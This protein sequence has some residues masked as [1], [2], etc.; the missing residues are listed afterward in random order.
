MATNI[1]V[2]CSDDQSYFDGSKLLD[3]MSFFKSKFTD[4]GVRFSKFRTAVP[5][6]APGRVCLLTGLHQDEHGLIYNDFQPWDHA[7]SI[8]TAL[9]TAGYR[10][11]QVGKW[12][13]R[14]GLAK[15][16]RMAKRVPPGWNSWYAFEDSMFV[17]G[18]FRAAGLGAEPTDGSTNQV[19]TPAT[20]PS[21]APKTD[22]TVDSGYT[23]GYS[24]RLLAKRAWDVIDA[25]N[26]LNVPL[27]LWVAPTAPHP[28]YTIEGW[29]QSGNDAT[30]GF[31]SAAGSWN[32]ANFNTVG[33]D[34]PNW[35]STL[36]SYNGGTPEGLE[37]DERV[38]QSMDDLF[39]QVYN[40]MDAEGRQSGA[41]STLYIYVADNGRAWGEH[42][43]DKKNVAHLAA[44]HIPFAAYWANGSMGAPR[45]V[46]SLWS[47]IDLAP[48]LAEVAVPGQDVT[49]TLGYTP[50]GQSF[51]GQITN[52]GG[53]TPT[54]RFFSIATSEP[55]NSIPLWTG[56]ETSTGDRY[57]KYP[58]EANTPR[59]NEEFYEIGS[60]SFEQTNRADDGGAYATRKAELVTLLESLQ[61]N[62]E[63][64]IF[65]R[66]TDGRG[67]GTVASATAD[68][69]ATTLAATFG[70]DIPVG[71]HVILVVSASGA[72]GVTC[73]AADSP[74]NNTYVTDWGNGASD[75]TG[76]ER[77]WFISAKVTDAI[78]NGADTL[79]ATFSGAVT[80]RRMVAYHYSGLKSTGWFRGAS[81]QR[82]P[83]GNDNSPT[84][85]AVTRGPAGLVIGAF[86]TGDSAASDG[87]GW[88]LRHNIAGGAGTR[89]LAVV[90]N[91][92]LPHEP[93]TFAPSCELGAAAAWVAVAAAY[94]Q[95]NA[96]TPETRPLPKV[97]AAGSST[98][99]GTQFTIERAITPDADNPIFFIISQRETGTPA[100]SPVEPTISNSGL[101]WDTVQ[102]E[103][104][105]TTKQHRL[106]VLRSASAAPGTFTP[107]IDFTATQTAVHWA[108]VQFDG[109]DVSGTRA[110]GSVV[111]AADN[112]GD[113]SI[114]QLA[115]T[116]S[117]FGNWNNGCLYVSHHSTN[118]H[119]HPDFGL[120]QLVSVDIATPNTGLG[121]FWAPRPITNPRAC[122]NTGSH[123]IAIALELKS[124][125]QFVPQSGGFSHAVHVRRARWR[126]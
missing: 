125:S 96:P 71:E 49:T 119:T 77:I 111:Q 25:E 86:S 108:V 56:V 51:K 61:G 60:D 99:D 92:H 19:T 124:E 53:A 95:E 9:Q 74:S 114:Q 62:F 66:G 13:N 17:G 65:N 22:G 44:T 76:T 117:S 68:A 46:S 104:H 78:V 98:T 20:N 109:V 115:V 16:M 7:R 30:S 31:V 23:G 79:T 21:V 55:D 34:K 10:T 45:T 64:R 5:R 112:Q 47:Q 120:K 75:Q 101:T 113:T 6:C 33:A 126:R 107:R 82:I 4:N 32:P 67:A 27:F 123:G 91:V 87:S 11:H 103:F 116:L 18:V 88:F 106:T 38:M 102:T 84:C 93:T 36:P 24:V 35:M 39:Q 8:A 58:W 50:D 70:K 26:D 89:R 1:V 121:V 83:S 90:D 80:N 40:K 3:Q 29:W 81:L 69:S 52:D 105:A 85:H 122:W 12:L 94:D 73:T 48:T 15:D 57:W 110:S 63:N 42:R 2:I 37:D 28:P 100:V 97:L 118:E 14:Y 72:S 54:E 59:P 41:H 43:L